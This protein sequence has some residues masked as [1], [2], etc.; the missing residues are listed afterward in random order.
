NRIGM[1]LNVE[2]GGWINENLFLGGSFSTH[3][4]F[5]GVSRYGIVTVN[6]NDAGVG[7]LN[8]NVFLKPCF[9]LGQSA[10]SPGESIPILVDNGSENSFLECRSEGNNHIFIRTTGAS[11]FNTATISYAPR[12]TTFED[13]GSSPSTLFKDRKK[14]LNEN[15]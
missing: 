3:L 14:L 7:L 2:A 6:Q 8:A 11:R 9:E 12:G 4:I 10:S 1:R 5:P 15:S 13:L